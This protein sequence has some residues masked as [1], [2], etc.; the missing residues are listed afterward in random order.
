M[1]AIFGHHAPVYADAGLPTFPVDTR[2]KRPRVKRWQGTTLRHSRAWAR[3]PE[4]G[5]ADGLGLLMGKPSGIVEIDVDAVGTA[6]LGAALDRFGDTPAVIQTASQKHKLWYRHNGEGRHIRPLTGW[7]ID[8]LGDGYSICPPSEREDLGTSYRFLH[9][10]L[11]D[12]G[13]LPKMREGAFD[14]RPTRAAEGVLPGMRNDTVW[15]WCM[16]EARHCDDAE[17]LIDAALTWAARMPDPLPAAEIEKCARSAMRYEVTGRNFI[18][19]R[20]P[21][22]DAGAR[23]MDQLIDAPDAYL[24]HAMFARFHGHRAEFVIAPRAMSAAGTP[25][26]RYERIERARDLLIERGFIEEIEPPGRGRN[27]GRYRL[28]DEM[29]DFRHNNLTPPSPTHQPGRAW[30]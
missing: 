12:V 28:L 30:G 22:F 10:S 9:G 27:P 23:I 15:R 11:A 8:A 18:G 6:W 19:T 16:Q 21:Q 5:A 17:A 1:T 29:P 7:P 2:A 3:S 26:W 14:L 13:R 25:P 4:L 24:L 20:K